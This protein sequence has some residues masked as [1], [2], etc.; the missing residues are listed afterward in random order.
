M[1]KKWTDLTNIEIR[2]KYL[3]PPTHDQ[4][5]GFIGELG[6]SCLQ[7]ERYFFIPTGT[8]RG[9]SFGNRNLPVKFWPI[10][11][12]RIVPQY[13]VKYELAKK[14]VKNKQKTKRK[15]KAIVR[16]INVQNHDRLSNVK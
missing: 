9:V 11:Y 10:F 6:V 7:F 14:E 16:Q 12:E 4:I 15:P 5:F 2:E 8:L 13:G 3:K 1:L